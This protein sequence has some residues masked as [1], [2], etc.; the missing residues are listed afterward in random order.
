MD[1]S[2]CIGFYCQTKTDFDN[3]VESV[4]MVSNKILIS[5]ANNK[6]LTYED[7]NVWHYKS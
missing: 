6:L 5:F 1:P 7:N 2:C 3:F 4:Q